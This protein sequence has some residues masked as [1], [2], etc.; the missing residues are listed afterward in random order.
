MQ[1]KN[2]I[3]LYHGESTCLPRTPQTYDNITGL[4]AANRYSTSLSQV[5]IF[6]QFGKY[7]NGGGNSIPRLV[8]NGLTE[9]NNQ[10]SSHQDVRRKMKEGVL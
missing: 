6:A 10:N 8:S 7:W 2:W 9:S 5:K 1:E 4:D 3:K